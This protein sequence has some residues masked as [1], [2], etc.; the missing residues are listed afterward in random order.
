MELPMQEN[1][2]QPT[3]LTKTKPKQIEGKGK[4]Q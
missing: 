3:R 2:V 1:M 4:E